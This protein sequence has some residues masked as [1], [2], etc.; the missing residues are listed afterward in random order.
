[1]TLLHALQVIR[2][3]KELFEPK[4][5]SY[6]CTGVVECLVTRQNRPLQNRRTTLSPDYYNFDY[7]FGLSVRAGDVGGAAPPPTGSNE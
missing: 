6:F 5:K 1:M 2:I 4:S 7:Y 3:L